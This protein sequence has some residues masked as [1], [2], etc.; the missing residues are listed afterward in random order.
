MNNNYTHGYRPRRR[1][2]PRCVRYRLI[3]LAKLEASYFGSDEKDSGNFILIA[4]IIVK[5]Y[6]NFIKTKTTWKQ[7]KN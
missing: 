2:F 5:I 4:V 3:Q 6:L 7:L 1:H